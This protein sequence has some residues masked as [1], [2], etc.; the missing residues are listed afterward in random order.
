MRIPGSTAPPSGVAHLLKQFRLRAGLTQEGLAARAGLSVEGIRALEGGRRR[1]PRAATIDQLALALRLSLP[2]QRQLTDAAD[3]P[4]QSRAL[5]EQL[6]PAPD[7][8]TGRDRE[9]N[10]LVRLLRTTDLRVDSRA[11]VISAVG[12]MGGV[13]KTALAIQAGHLVAPDYP[14]GQIY[15]NLGGG[16]QEPVSTAGALAAV[17]RSLGVPPADDPRDVEQAVGRYRTA[18]AHRRVLLLLDDADGV[19]QVLPLIPGTRGSAVVITSRK[20]LTALPGVRYLGLQVLTEEDGLSLLGEVAGRDRVAAEPEAAL[21]LVRHCGLLPLA[22]RIAG[23][24]PSIQAAGGLAALVGLLA[25]DGSRLDALSGGGAGGGIRATIVSSLRSLAATDRPGDRKCSEM[26]PLLALSEG[27]HFPLR[28]AAK[29]LE[30]PLDVTEDLLERLV[31]VHL[32]ETPAPQ[33]Y[34]MH[35]LVRDVG[36]ELAAGTMT[37]AERAEASRR[38][39]RCYLGVLWRLSELHELPHPKGAEDWSAGAED[40]GDR[41]EVA[42]WL[43]AE[44]GNVLRLIAKAATGGREDRLTAA[45]TGLGMFQF[46]R[47]RLRFAESRDA[48]AAV[49][50]ILDEPDDELDDWLWLSLGRLYTALDQ[51]R[52]AA[53]CIRIALRLARAR[54]DLDQVVNCLIEL[55]YVLVRIGEPAEAKAAVDEVLALPPEDWMHL[56]AAVRLVAGSAAGALGDLAGQRAAFDRVIAVHRERGRGRTAL[57]HQEQMGMSLVESGQYDAGWPMLAE[58][59]ERA[60]ADG[61]AMIEFDL[62][63]DFG[64]GWSLR[65]D[66]QQAR[67]YFEQALEI[68]I[69]F[70]AENQEGRTLDRLGRTLLALGRPEEARMHWQRAVVLYQ[71]FA[72]PAADEVQELLD[73]LPSTD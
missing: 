62:L 40:L 72:D 6:P 21:Q 47:V 9:L 8:F 45:R 33:Q 50:G 34:R 11:V 69:R 20:Q 61:L 26:F 37:S 29:V 60:R 64:K 57:L 17:L 39:L 36:Q 70:P 5:P 35:D 31:D 14:D 73:V 65:G 44:V 27:D 48:L 38:E 12:G 63:T 4:R 54:G 15:L 22:V 52:S 25:D 32:L 7:D 41:D 46:A 10:D 68:A 23:G 13:G 55:A 56:E 28:T 1:S 2:E 49:T 66:H 18:L 43:E 42:R 71:Q 30:L 3:P 58:A 53:D 67:E 19:D 16:S 51:P 59:L 24:H